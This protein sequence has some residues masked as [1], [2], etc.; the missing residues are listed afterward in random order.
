MVVDYSLNFWEAYVQGGQWAEQTKIDTADMSG[1]WLF[2]V[3]PAPEDV[4]SNI[5][6]ALSRG[7]SVGGEKG[8][9][10][11]YFDNIAYN[12]GGESLSSPSFG[13]GTGG[14]ETWAGYPVDA[15]GNADTGAW[16]G[17]INVT[18]APWV[19]S[20]DLEQYVYLDEA[21]VEGGGSWMYI[22]NM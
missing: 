17:W 13:G 18:N 7:N 2:R 6:I 11:T 22:L 5:L 19:Y 8:I 3:N 1:I 16:M 21:Y 12:L 4:V 20:Y 15:G 10:P 9:D 14:G